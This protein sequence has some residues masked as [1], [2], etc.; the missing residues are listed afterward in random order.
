ME[1]KQYTSEYKQ[2]A[3]ELVLSSGKKTS[4]FARDLGINS[5][6]LNRWCR[7]QKTHQSHSFSGSGKRIQGTE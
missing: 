2:R 3:V 7:E 6:I 5:N 4:E 1:R